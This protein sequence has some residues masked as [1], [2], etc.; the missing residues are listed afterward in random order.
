[1][2][3]TRLGRYMSRTAGQQSNNTSSW[4]SINP[5]SSILTFWQI[6]L[7]PTGGII[8]WRTHLSTDQRGLAGCYCCS[9]STAFWLAGVHCWDGIILFIIRSYV[10]IEFVDGFLLLPMINQKAVVILLARVLCGQQKH[11][12]CASPWTPRYGTLK[13]WKATTVSRFNTSAP[14][15]SD[16]ECDGRPYH[17]AG[18]SHLTCCQLKDG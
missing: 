8:K 6:A 11:V 17:R 13:N 9:G 10:M 3:S 7:A 4:A 12:V 1:M 14:T 5:S 16:A 15:V 18:G 2:P